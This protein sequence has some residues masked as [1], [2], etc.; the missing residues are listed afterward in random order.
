[1]THDWGHEITG[2]PAGARTAART[3]HDDGKIIDP[4]SIAILVM[5]IP[6]AVL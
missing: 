5:S 6:P 4:V 1:M 3:I 2:A